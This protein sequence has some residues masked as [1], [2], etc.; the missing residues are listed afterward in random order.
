MSVHR[1]LVKLYKKTKISHIFNSSDHFYVIHEFYNKA[2]NRNREHF[3][4]S[5]KDI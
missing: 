1:N 3:K 5:T 2:T 4:Y